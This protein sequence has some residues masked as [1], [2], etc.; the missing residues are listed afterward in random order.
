V[1]QTREWL[2][3]LEATQ[4]VEP[5]VCAVKQEGELVGYFTGAVF[6]RYG[7]RILGSPFPGWTTGYMGFNLR[8]EQSRP[9]AAAALFRYA[10]GSLG[11]MHVELRDRELG[12]DD[13][14][15]LSAT[16]NHFVT[17]E[18]DLRPSEDEIF[19]RMS[20]APRWSIRKAPKLGVTIEEAD[21]LGFADDYHAQLEDVFAKQ[22]LR[23]T[24]GVERMRALI[25][26]LHPT[27]RLLLLRARG[28]DGA[29][30]ATGIFPAYGSVMYYLGGASWRSGQHLR[31]NEALMWHGMRYWKT[32]G[33]TTCDMGGGG[34][35]KRKY[36]TVDVSFP[37]LIKSRLPGVIQLRGIA[38]RL[39]SAHGLARRIR[40]AG[41]RS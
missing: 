19:S 33:I 27:G 3:F 7:L 25:E 16:T 36:G 28:P 23:P 34:D 14:A 24:Y 8:S 31:P 18:V 41:R 39:Y 38:E 40:Y 20:K 30:I 1:F 9:Q 32:R 13:A 15:L 37:H 29:C 21:D 35:Y 2:S 17:L 6:K 11:C 12:Y 22:G 10:I 26:H 5:L 4:S